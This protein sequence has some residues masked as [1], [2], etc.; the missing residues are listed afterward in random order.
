MK[1]STPMELVLVIIILLFGAVMFF[2]NIPKV[3]LT[4]IDEVPSQVIISNND[5]VVYR[6]YSKNLNRS[7]YS[8]NCHILIQ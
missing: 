4:T 2:T 5:C 7:V 6:S 3:D 8:S 1:I